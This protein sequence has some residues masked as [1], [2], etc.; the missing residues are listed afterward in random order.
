MRGTVAGLPT[1]L[2]CCLAASCGQK[3]SAPA[4]AQAVAT[5]SQD[6][7]PEMAPRSGTYGGVL[8]CADCEGIRHTLILRPDGVF[9]LRMTYLGKGEGDSFDDIGRWVASADGTLSLDGNREAPL[10]F[11]VKG[12]GVLRMLDIEGRPIPSELN[13]DLLRAE[14]GGVAFEPRLPMKGMYSY[15]ADAGLF[16]ECLTG[17]RL[18]VAM[19]ADN[20]A[21]ERAYV[22]ARETPGQPLLVSVEGRIARRP[23]MEGSGDQEALVPERFIKVSPGESCDSAPSSPPL[24]DTHWTLVRL[25][26]EPVVARP[27]KRA[28]YLTLDPS[29]KSLSGFASCNRVTGRYEVDGQK[30]RLGPIALTRMACTEGM[31]LERAFVETLQ[32]V[33]GW[34]IVNEALELSDAEGRLVARLE[35]ATPR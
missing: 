33:A 5:A 17:L 30:L 3:G 14:G 18:P 10:K 32:L 1:M 9:F 23:R 8:P 11:A 21:L 25:G 15:M 2:A 27:G 34:R 7:A 24:E 4:P 20:A 29:T 12:P 13:H 26:D 16:T 28:P 6:A 19:E 22:A 35:A 31:E